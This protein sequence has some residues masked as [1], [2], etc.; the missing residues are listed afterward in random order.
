MEICSQCN[1]SGEGYTEDSRCIYCKGT[2]ET[3]V[4]TYDIE[5]EDLQ[6]E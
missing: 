2:G 4:N 6:D 1:G 5:E 3:P